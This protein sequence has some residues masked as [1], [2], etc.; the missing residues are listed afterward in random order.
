MS[1]LFG[2]RSNSAFQFSNY[3]AISSVI[4]HSGFLI[5]Y[6]YECSTCRYVR[7]NALNVQYA[8]GPHFNA[9]SKSI[10]YIWQCGTKMTSA[11]LANVCGSA[12][13]IKVYRTGPLGRIRKAEL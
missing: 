6:L 9:P 4:R 7:L 1:L 12:E 13:E 10:V 5:I 8:H 3:A 11:I 2:L